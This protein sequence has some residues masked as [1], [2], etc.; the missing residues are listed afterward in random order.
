MTNVSDVEDQYQFGYASEEPDTLAAQVLFLT[1]QL[2]LLENDIDQF[3]DLYTSRGAS[4]T[5]SMGFPIGDNLLVGQQTTQSQSAYLR[6]FSSQVSTWY[7]PTSI[8]QEFQHSTITP[9]QI[10]LLTN[11]TTAIYM[12]TGHIIFSSG[13]P[14]AGV[15]RTRLWTSTGIFE[16][17]YQIPHW[18][19][20]VLDEGFAMPTASVFQKGSSAEWIK[21]EVFQDSQ[22]PS[23]V[24]GYVNIHRIA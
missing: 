16:D 13:T 4:I 1:E 3:S 17:L 15:V 6:M 21:L 12:V 8:S 22:T 18:R 10:D 20:N 7:D 2:A 11:D 9:T 19:T 5:A 23:T 24:S 14:S